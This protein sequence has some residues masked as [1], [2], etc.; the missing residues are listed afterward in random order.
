MTYVNEVIKAI[1]NL[2]ERQND[3]ELA[4]K[5]VIAITKNYFPSK[6]EVDA[7]SYYLLN[8]P[9]IGDRK[10]RQSLSLLIAHSRSPEL[11]DSFVPLANMALSL[12]DWNQGFTTGG[13]AAVMREV[14]TKHLES[15]PNEILETVFKDSA[16]LSSKL[17][18][19]IG[20]FGVDNVGPNF[21][22][23]RDIPYRDNISP[24]LTMNQML[25][26]LIRH[27]FE[28]GL[29]VIDTEGIFEG[30]YAEKEF[31][32]LI[33]EGGYAEKEFNGLCRSISRLRNNGCHLGMVT[34]DV[35][36]ISDLIELMSGALREENREDRRELI[37]Q[38]I[39]DLVYMSVIPVTKRLPASGSIFLPE[40]KERNRFCGNEY[41]FDWLRDN[42]LSDRAHHPEADSA[43]SVF[44]HHLLIHLAVSNDKL[45]RNMNI[46]PLRV[47]AD[48]F[49]HKCADMLD[50]KSA[51]TKIAPELR[52]QIIERIEDNAVRQ[53]L[54]KHNP[55]SRRRAMEQDLGI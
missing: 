15:I 32:G 36:L 24:R 48:A 12:I 2:E 41:V 9:L 29:S 1:K 31:N 4:N 13:V 49:A 35:I 37:A 43:I 46:D 11:P 47:V 22:S 30:G 27:H 23:L 17:T 38:S 8:S 39:I 21:E 20:S 6:E 52:T 14:I 16:D 10:R 7:I 40:K 45:S 26:G 5:A 44:Y 53:T 55:R 19:Q 25:I 50:S 28:D 3:Y 54:I 42:A 33:F 18:H 34:G 51:L